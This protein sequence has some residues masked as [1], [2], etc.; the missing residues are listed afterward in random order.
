MRRVGRG[1]KTSGIKVKKTG[2]GIWK[3]HYEEG[4]KWAKIQLAGGIKVIKLVKVLK[5]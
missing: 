2:K 5:G 3:P 1:Q 4:G